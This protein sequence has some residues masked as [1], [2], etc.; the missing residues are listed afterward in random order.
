MFGP[1]FGSERFDNCAL[2]S[3]REL[4]Q[5]DPEQSVGSCKSHRGAGSRRLKTLSCCQKDSFYE[6]LARAGGVNCGTIRQQSF[7]YDAFGNIVKSGSSSFAATYL[8]GM[9]HFGLSGV[10]VQY[11]GDENLLTDK[12][13]KLTL[14][15]VFGICLGMNL[16]AVGI[17]WNLRGLLWFLGRHCSCAGDSMMPLFLSS[18]GQR[19]GFL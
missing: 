7:T 18:N 13:E 9:N 3:C 6:D 2:P 12:Q 16:L 10:S 5:D 8:S 4:P 19:D 11:D 14:D 15:S 17:C 1:D